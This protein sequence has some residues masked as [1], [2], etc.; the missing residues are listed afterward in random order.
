M[1]KEMSEGGEKDERGERKK[2]MERRMGEEIERSGW[3]EG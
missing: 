1:G 2:W 3:K